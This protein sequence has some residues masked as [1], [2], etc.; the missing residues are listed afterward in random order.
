MK[1]ILALLFSFL[2][3]HRP[4]SLGFLRGKILL[5]FGK[6]R[7]RT[8]L[9]PRT[10]WKHVRTRTITLGSAPAVTAQ[11]VASKALQQQH[12]G[13][14]NFGSHGLQQ[15]CAP[16]WG[17][18]AFW[19]MSLLDVVFHLIWE[20]TGTC[21]WYERA[22]KKQNSTVSLQSAIKIEKSLWF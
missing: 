17:S 11:L 1:T 14:E 7:V 5:S 19:E 9:Q 13:A 22:G 21:G 15:T 16:A 12:P 18:S 10:D 4:V 2:A 8:H 6:A 3:N 20:Q